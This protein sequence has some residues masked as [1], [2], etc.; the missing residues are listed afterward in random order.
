MLAVNVCTHTCMYYYFFE[1]GLLIL[2]SGSPCLS[3]PSAGPTGVHNHTWLFVILKIAVE[4]ALT[5]KMTFEPKLQRD[6]PLAIEAGSRACS[7]LFMTLLG[8][9]GL[10][11]CT[12][13]VLYMW[14]LATLAAHLDFHPCK[15]LSPHSSGRACPGLT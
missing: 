9:E 1:Q 12:S 3:L 13:K 15:E 6:K 10:G 8:R 7:N 4:R 2:T 5:V 11:T 14:H